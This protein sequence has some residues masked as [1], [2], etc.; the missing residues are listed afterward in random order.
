MFPEISSGGG[1]VTPDSKAGY[2][3]LAHLLDCRERLSANLDLDLDVDLVLDPDN[4]KSF[5]NK[6]GPT[7]RPD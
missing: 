7:P 6:R 4:A 1:I 2:G 5:M 3:I